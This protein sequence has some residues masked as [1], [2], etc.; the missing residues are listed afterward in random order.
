VVGVAT[1]KTPTGKSS[2]YGCES[3]EFRATVHCSIG[4]GVAEIEGP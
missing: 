3:H 1:I 2:E 4:D